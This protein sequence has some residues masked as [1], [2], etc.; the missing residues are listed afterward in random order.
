MVSTIILWLTLLFFE[1]QYGKKTG[2]KMFWKIVTG[3]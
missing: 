2:P 1:Y 3:S